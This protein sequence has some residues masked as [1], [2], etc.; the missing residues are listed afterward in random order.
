MADHIKGT[1]TEIIQYSTS[2]M[3]GA[4]PTLW[5][6]VEHWL[7]YVR[8]LY[9]AQTTPQRRIKKIPQYGTV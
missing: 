8:S 5:S 3:L 4:M 2:Q 6:G 1:N 9:R 7:K